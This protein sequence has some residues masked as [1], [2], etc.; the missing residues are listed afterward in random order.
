MDELAHIPAGYDYL[1][2]LDYRLNPEH[3]PLVKVLSAVPLVFMDLRFPTGDPSWT[4]DINGQWVAGNKFIYHS[5]NNADQLVFWARLGPIILTL[6]LIILIYVW[7]REL[8]GDWW[9]FLPT[10]LFAFS[11]TVLAHGHYVTTDVGAALG[12]VSGTY[13]FIKFLLKPT[14]KNLLLAGLSLGAAQLLKFSAVLLIPYFIILVLFWFFRT[15]KRSWRQ[16]LSL[17]A[18]F[19][20]AYVLVYLVYYIFTLNYPLSKQVAD[21]KFILT[22]FKHRLFA[23][24]DVFMAGNQFLRPLGHY[25]LGVLMVGQRSV[26]GNTAYFLGQ[27]S[28]AGWWYYFPVVFLL[29]E[30][31][32]SLVLIFTALILGIWGI[33]KGLKLQKFKLSPYGRSPEGKQ[34]SELRIPFF[35][36]NLKAFNDYLGT[37]FAEFS[38][39]IFVVFYWLYSIQGKLNIGVRH[40][41]PTLPFIY[42]LMTAGLKNWVNS[43]FWK[44]A[45]KISFI[46]IFVF[47]YL[48]EMIW[49]YPYYLSYFNQFGGGVA[50]GYRI[51]TDS[52]YDWGQ[53]LKRLAAFV[54]E[55]GIQKIAVDYF[56]GGDT[57][58]FLG[59]KAE[60]WW[61]GRGNPK[62]A[63]IEW[64]A[65]SVNAL[66]GA[67][68][69]TA[70]GF[71][72]KPEDEYRWL[73]AIKNPF[74]PDFKAGT[75]I[76]IYHL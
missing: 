39:I 7:A 50:N 15:K 19:I 44:Y 18:I 72:R 10:F 31:V 21:T 70:P 16:F 76:F 11:P 33:I 24:L 42:I 12:V 68:A 22:S 61:S 73:Q 49:A 27:V 9:G 8:L 37:H 60:N 38:M 53:D 36:Y 58:Y 32:P 6:L 3:P 40:I 28:A 62:E 45:F 54:E 75:S 13:F 46:F 57:G 52:N 47:W 23:D 20:I 1:K 65:V 63:G 5:G 67:L 14:S 48:L 56:G 64:L 35:S 4:T 41:L 69:K 29:K 71:E 26:S 43:R 55:K 25:L 2:Y 51:V 30:P 59:D 66:Q 34:E 17:V 74:E